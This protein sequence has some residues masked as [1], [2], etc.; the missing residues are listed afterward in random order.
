M[1]IWSESVKLL[2]LTDAKKVKEHHPQDPVIFSVIIFII[3]IVIAMV[4]T[5]DVLDIVQTVE[6]MDEE[7]ITT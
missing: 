6:K 3:I 2:L 1:K 4:S 7:R 5:Y